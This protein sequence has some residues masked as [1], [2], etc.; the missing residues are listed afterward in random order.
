MAGGGCRR[1]GSGHDGG[2]SVLAPVVAELAGEGLVELLWGMGGLLEGL[3]GG[4]EAWSG[5]LHGEV[6]WRRDGASVQRE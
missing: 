6:Q 2:A 5:G 3:G 1:R 4:C